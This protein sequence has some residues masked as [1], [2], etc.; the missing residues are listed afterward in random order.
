MATVGKTHD[1]FM[2]DKEFL[3]KAIFK[4]Q[5]SVAAGGFPASAI[6][7]KDREIIGVGLSIGNVINDPTSHGEQAAIR[8]A[9]KKL[10][11]SDL[12]GATLYASLQPCVMC[13]TAAMWSK[14]GRIVFACAQDKL[15]KEYYGSTHNSLK[16][17]KQFIRPIEIEQIKDFEASALK[18]VKEW[19]STV[20][21]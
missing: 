10:A 16:I 20:N 1:N 15:N 8:E 21:N 11:T 17:N 2:T 9:C 14:V 3:E 4:A 18:I 5:E 12:S 6:L 13:L 7:V 19:E